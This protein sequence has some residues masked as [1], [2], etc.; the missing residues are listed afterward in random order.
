MVS[1]TPLWGR[2]KQGK[3]LIKRMDQEWKSNICM[4]GEYSLSVMVIGVTIS[5]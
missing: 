2:N 4:I 3:K 5:N 1:I